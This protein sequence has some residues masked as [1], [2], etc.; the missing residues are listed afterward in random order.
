MEEKRVAA[1]SAAEALAVVEL[2]RVLLVEGIPAIAKA[3][4]AW[5]KKDPGLE[6]FKALLMALKKPEKTGQKK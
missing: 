6:D 2:G 3:I 1:F 4:K 5:E